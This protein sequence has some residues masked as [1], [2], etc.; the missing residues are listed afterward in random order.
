MV[1]L[2]QADI[3]AKVNSLVLYHAGHGD[4]KIRPDVVRFDGK[5]VHFTDGTGSIRNSVYEAQPMQLKRV[6]C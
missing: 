3:G 1:L 2:R 4:L 5:T 6:I